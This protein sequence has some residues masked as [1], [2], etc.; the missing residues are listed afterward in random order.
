MNQ[1]R[2]V[3]SFIDDRFDLTL[4]CIRR[5]YLGHESPLYDTLLRYNNFFEL[6]EG[7]EGYFQFFLLDDLVDENQNIRFYLPFDNFETRPVFTSIDEYLMYKKGVMNFIESRNKR[8]ETC[9]N[10]RVTK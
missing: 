8:I 6:F 10:Q 7:F 9:V 3:N 5:F 4:E 1:A 2:G